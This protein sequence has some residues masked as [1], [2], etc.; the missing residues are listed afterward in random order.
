MFIELFNQRRLNS[1][2]LSLNICV[3]SGS[4]LIIAYF[5]HTFE[6]FSN[7]LMNIEFPIFFFTELLLP[8][9]LYAICISK[10]NKVFC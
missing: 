6:I 3:L 5:N 10:L 8:R 7:I 2:D 1:K 4:F 9:I